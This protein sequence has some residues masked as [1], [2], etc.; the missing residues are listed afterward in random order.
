MRVMIINK[1]DKHSE[2]GEMPSEKLFAGMNALLG[3]L[4]RAG[5][6]VA[7]EG[8]QSSARGVRLNVSG[9]N[10]TVTDGPF[11]ETKE[12]IAGFTIIKVETMDEAIGWA[13]KMADVF[14]GEVDGAYSLELRRLF[15]ME[16]FGETLTPELREAEGRRRAELVGQR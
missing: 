9:M 14:E 6:L 5:I 10:R 11:T 2:A 8:I 7:A 13:Q 1:A 16:D 15:D 4:G 3:E 12:L